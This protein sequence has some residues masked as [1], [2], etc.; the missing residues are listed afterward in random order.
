MLDPGLRTHLHRVPGTAEWWG[1]T[2]IQVTQRFNGHVVEKGRRENINAFGNLTVPG[3]EQLCS[4]QAPTRP[5][6]GEMDM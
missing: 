2:E 6:A 5:I 1:I 3:A 4:E